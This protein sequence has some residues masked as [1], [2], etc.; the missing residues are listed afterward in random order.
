MRRFL[1]VELPAP[2]REALAALSERWK[3]LGGWRW[4]RSEA[5][6]LTLRFLGEVAP[7]LDLRARDVWRRAAGTVGPF[8]LRLSGV[9]SFPAGRRPRVLWVAAHDRGD[10]LTA[11]AAALE[12]AARELGFP[13]AERP[14]RP[15]VT[16]ARAARGA[17]PVAPDDDPWVP[18]SVEVGEVV[19]F[20]SQLEASGARYTALERFPL[21]GGRA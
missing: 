20:R 1:A 6:H 10:R 15:H 11:V 12:T 9:G 21:G 5:L 3:G 13:P 2:T 19:L 8:R 17:R 4:V 18:Q 7:A 14:F 16:V